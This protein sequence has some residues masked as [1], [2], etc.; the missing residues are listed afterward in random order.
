MTETE[1]L[2][3]EQITELTD[4]WYKLIGGDHHKDRDC[5]WY[6]ETRWSY[7]YPPK[8]F[9]QH[10]GYIVNDIE[11]ECDTYE[12]ALLLLKETIT[13]QIEVYKTNSIEE[14]NYYNV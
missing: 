12:K 4:E 5:H 8:Y 1:C 2:I 13:K 7:G 10:F 14:E 3:V 9:V 6:I 11:V